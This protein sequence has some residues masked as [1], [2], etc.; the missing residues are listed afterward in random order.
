MPQNTLVTFG[1]MIDRL[2]TR[3]ITMDV[4]ASRSFPRKLVVDHRF[5]TLIHPLPTLHRDRG[6]LE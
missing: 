3:M 4:E 2:I 5:A 6:L 1:V